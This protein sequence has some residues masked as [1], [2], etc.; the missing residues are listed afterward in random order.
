MTVEEIAKA[1]ISQALELLGEV[2]EDSLSTYGFAAFRITVDD[3]SCDLRMESIE[4]G[5]FYA[6]QE[7][8]PNEA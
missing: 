8:L 2:Y 3:V 4:P 1:M 7:A 5:D 6:H